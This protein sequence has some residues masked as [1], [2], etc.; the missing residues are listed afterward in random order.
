MCYSEGGARDSPRY[1]S[2]SEVASRWSVSV[3]LVY[4]I[5]RRGELKG[6]KIGKSTWRVSEDSIKEYETRNTTTEQ[7]RKSKKSKPVLR[8]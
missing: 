5:L 7:P 8:I 2:V 6:L 1:L 4:D 3:D